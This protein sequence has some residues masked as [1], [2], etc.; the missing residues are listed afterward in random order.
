MRRLLLLRPEPGLSRSAERAR[1]LGMEP[2]LAPLFETQPVAWSPPAPA[3]YDALLLTSANAVRQAGPGLANFANLPAHA[4]GAATAIAARD[5][6]LA[7]SSVG[8]SDI[9]GLLAELEPPLRLLHLAGE[10][11]RAVQSRH[12]I[13]V[14]AVYRAATIEAPNLPSMKDF[15][16]AVHS[17]R[18]GHRLSELVQDRAGNA[19]V[20]I[21]VEAAAACDTGWRSVAIADRPDDDR[22][23]ALAAR[24]CHTSDPR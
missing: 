14:I 15:V 5:A 24:L 7:V 19:I 4:V 17:P 3:E 6:G 10:D 1:A 23:L 9:E 18:A 13:D 2:V 12:A 8:T 20:A 11:H 21:S 16:V 22:L